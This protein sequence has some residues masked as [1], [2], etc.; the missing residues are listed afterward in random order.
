MDKRDI[1]K[2][3]DLTNLKPMASKKDIKDLFDKAVE[4]ECASVCVAPAMVSVAKQIR[5][6]YI[7]ENGSCNVKICTVIG[8][9]NGYNT[10]TI[11]CK[12]T[13][14]AIIDGADEVD[15][16][17]NIGTVKEHDFESVYNEFAA[18]R[19]VA[20]GDYG[21]DI[22]VKMI[23][24]TCYLDEGEIRELCRVADESAID[25]VKTSTG[26]GV[27]TAGRPSG[28]TIETIAII[29][30]EVNKI[31]NTI[32]NKLDGR[33]LKVKASGGIR[34]FFFASQLIEMGVSRIGASNLK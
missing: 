8:F 11:K 6:K 30:D 21:R 4:N 7:E 17:V 2:I 5:D 15:V 28:A 9:P 33:V 34:D 3:V 29:M 24:E 27:P 16:V 13:E 18:I 14:C 32:E 12:E 10:T 1:M 23:M 25:F 31:N 26:F 19:K 20:D 22:I